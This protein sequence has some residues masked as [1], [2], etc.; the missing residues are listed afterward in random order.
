[1]RALKSDD[2]GLTESYSSTS[3]VCH[4]K[5]DHERSLESYG[6]TLHILKKA[7]DVDH[8][9]VAECLD[10]MGLVHNCAQR[11]SEAIEYH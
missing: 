2:P 5:D 3:C 4:H 11:Y 6:K 9:K 7:F 8:L 1:M 10:S